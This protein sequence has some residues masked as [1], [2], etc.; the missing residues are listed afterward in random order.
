MVERL[1]S[2]LGLRETFSCQAGQVRIKTKN[3]NAG[4]TEE[5]SHVVGAQIPGLMEFAYPPSEYYKFGI[6]ICIAACFSCPRR[7]KPKSATHVR[8][9]TCY[10][11]LPG[12]ILQLRHDS[13]APASPHLISRIWASHRK[14]RYLC[15]TSQFRFNYTPCLFV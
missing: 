3:A 15:C 9:I 13:T 14:F 11:P 7:R 2:F 5:T 12:L 6:P 8:R 1:P 10:L 4:L